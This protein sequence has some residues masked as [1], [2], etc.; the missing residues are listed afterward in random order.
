MFLET[1]PAGIFFGLVPAGRKL[2][3]LMC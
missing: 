1:R 3:L 2:I